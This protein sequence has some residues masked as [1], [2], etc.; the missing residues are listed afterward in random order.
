MA[1]ARRVP[2]EKDARG[3]AHNTKQ[4]ATSRRDVAVPRVAVLPEGRD[5]RLPG[6]EVCE[7]EGGVPGELSKHDIATDSLL[8][9]FL[10]WR[11]SEEDR[12]TAWDGGD[13]RRKAMLWARRAHPSLVPGAVDA[14]WTAVVTASTARRFGDIG[15]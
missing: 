6:E 15:L 13:P 4:R 12:S 5:G 8:Q 3:R 9:R 10:R 7:S 14:C 2:G 1:H 11:A